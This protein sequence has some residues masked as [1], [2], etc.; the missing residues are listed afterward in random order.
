MNISRLDLLLLAIMLFG[1]PGLSF[2]QETIPPTNYIHSKLEQNNI[3]FLGTTHQ[4]PEIL[5]FIAELIPTLKMVGV[6][7][8]GLEIP[9]DQ[10]TAID[11]Y[12]QTGSGLADIGLIHQIDCP[13]YRHLFEVLRKTGAINPVALD[14][15]FSMY[16]DDITRDEWIADCLVTEFQKN[17]QVKI[18]VIIGNLHIFKKLELQ[19]KSSR[20]RRA[21]RQ[22]IKKRQPW[23]NMWSI[24]Q[25]IDEDPGQ[26]D[27]DRKFSPLPG[28]VALDLDHRYH[29]WKFSLAAIINIY[30]AESYELVDGVIVY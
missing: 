26:C 28:A 8:V 21:I 2:A 4:T 22:Y 12:I 29:G 9:S 18:L 1:I 24:A 27:F 23:I 16:P 11:T 20:H 17:P 10:Q 15:P 19:P 30:P 13:E 6:T 25:L 3:V 7:H 5:G 14:L